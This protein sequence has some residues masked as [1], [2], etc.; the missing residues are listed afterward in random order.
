MTMSSR[1]PAIFQRMPA[2]CKTK[3]LFTSNGRRIV[4]EIIC[5]SFFLKIKFLK[6]YLND[7]KLL[8]IKNLLNFS[9][10]SHVR[11]TLIL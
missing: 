11:I 7:Y 3:F 1:W 5:M 10:S 2:F 4:Q 8:K 6:T 9:D